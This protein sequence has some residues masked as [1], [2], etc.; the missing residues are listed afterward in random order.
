MPRADWQTVFVTWVVNTAARRPGNATG[1]I[2]YTGAELFGTS[3]DAIFGS[4]ARLTVLGIAVIAQS[5]MYIIQVVT[6]INHVL[7]LHA[8]LSCKATL[9]CVP[10]VPLSIEIMKP[11]NHVSIYEYSV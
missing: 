7:S 6:I 1:E 10:V 2:V 11:Q 3:G 4:T 5:L 8:K 9:V